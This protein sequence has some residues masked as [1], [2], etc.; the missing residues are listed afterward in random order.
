MTLQS[1][2]GAR[3]L[4]VYVVDFDGWGRR[5]RVEAVDPA[6]GMVL[7]VR[8]VDNYQGGIHLSWTV[9]GNVV[10]R[11]TNTGPENVVVGGW[12][13]DPTGGL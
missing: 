2:G 5:F 6:S 4:S 10:L 7:D 9:T 1:D 8:D 12:F 13:V 3:R 11:F